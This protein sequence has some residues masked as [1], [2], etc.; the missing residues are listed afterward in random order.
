MNTIS[1]EQIDKVFAKA[2]EHPEPHQMDALEGIYQLMIPEW[3]RVRKMR[4]WPH[5]GRTLARY[6]INKFQEFDKKHH[7]QVIPAGIWINSGPG[8]DE[9][10]GDWEYSME[11]VEL[12]M[13]E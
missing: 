7:P 4:G 2:E 1:R 9:K 13:M 10:L 12:E 11:G 3:D 5:V 6:C 8:V